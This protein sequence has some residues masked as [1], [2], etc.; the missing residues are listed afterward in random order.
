MR[1]GGGADFNVLKSFAKICRY[2]LKPNERPPCLLP[3]GA[4]FRPCFRS[5]LIGQALGHAFTHALRQ[6]STGLLQ[7][8]VSFG[9]TF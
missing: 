1:C 3:R 4:H 2:H 8:Q 7:R 9:R 5:V 6:A